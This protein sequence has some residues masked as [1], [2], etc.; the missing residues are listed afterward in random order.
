MTAT[1]A[2]TPHPDE[3]PSAKRTPGVTDFVHP[4]RIF[5]ATGL[6]PAAWVIHLVTAV[7]LLNRACETGT[8][9]PVHVVTAVTLVAAIYGLV[10]AIRLRRSLSGSEIDPDMAA[11]VRFLAVLGIYL[12]A[13][14]SV[15]IVVES[16]PILVLEPCQP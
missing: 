13:L 8:R 2:P 12:A 10:S 16:I 11:R 9:W 1:D 4:V 5:A 14:F 7:V 15:L 6:A 3:M